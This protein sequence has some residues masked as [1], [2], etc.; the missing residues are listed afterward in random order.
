MTVDITAREI[1]VT[2]AIAAHVSRRVGFALGRFAPRLGRVAVRLADVNGPRGG[3]DKRCRIMVTLGRG[4]PVV[5]EEQDA[6]LYAAVDA[7]TGRAGR[8]VARSL[9]RASAR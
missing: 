4:G 9:A 1:P 3:A 5:V 7:A 6:D 2:P 8:A